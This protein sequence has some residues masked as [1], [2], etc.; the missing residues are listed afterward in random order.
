LPPLRP[1]STASSRF[2]AKPPPREILPSGIVGDGT[3]QSRAVADFHSSLSSR[4]PKPQ[5]SL[6]KET[7][8]PVAL[9]LKCIVS[10]TSSDEPSAWTVNVTVSA[11]ILRLSLS[12][13][14]IVALPVKLG[15]AG[16][17]GT[18][19][20][21]PVNVPMKWK[22]PL[23]VIVTWMTPFWTVV[24][25]AF[26]SRTGIDVVG[27]DRD[28]VVEDL[29]EGLRRRG[30]RGRRDDC[31]SQS[32]L[33]RWNA[34]PPGGTIV[35]P[36]LVG[37]LVGAPTARDPL[38]PLTPRGREV[39]PLIAQ[40]KT[41]R[42]MAEELFVTRKTVEAHV[43]SVLGKLDLPADATENPRVH[44]VLVFLRH[45]SSRDPGSA[46][47]GVSPMPEVRNRA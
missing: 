33:P 25:G 6:S 20:S 13:N 15:F 37:E 41:D 1:A 22:P 39:L 10:W 32:S 38:G 36:S 5:R 24:K 44:A 34:S 9:T 18:N 45:T 7:S 23:A 2:A 14:Q 11:S 46:T 26:F 21:V 29:R 47:T 17:S 8:S 40:G 31:R 16:S 3:E 30:E 12:P 43:R 42:G 19:S 35:E 27:I 28:C 4:F